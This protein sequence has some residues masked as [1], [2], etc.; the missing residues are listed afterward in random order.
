MQKINI[1]ID[2]KADVGQKGIWQYSSYLSLLPENFHLS[3][4]EGNTP[5]LPYKDLI[6]KREDQNPTGSLKDRGMAYQISWAFAR[7][8]NRL[9]LSSSG[10]AAI[11]AAA[12]SLLAGLDLTV[13]VSPK[14]G[15][16]KLEKLRKLG[17]KVNISSRAVSE[18]QKYSTQNNYLNLRPSRQEFGAEGYQ[19][20]AF[21]LAKAYGVINN[22]FLP[23]SSGVSLTGIAKGFKVL[24][25]LP[26][27][28]LCQPSSLC[29]IASL[30]DQDYQPEKTSLTTA[31]V[32]KFTP[33]KNE[34]IKII[35]ES[36]GTGWVI[37]NQD[38]VHEQKLLEKEGIIT[39]PEGALTVAA[40]T[41]AKNLGNISGKS[42][43]LLT[44]KRYG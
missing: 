41:K 2:I 43:C 32:A 28:H 6:L 30:Y 42:V 37:G 40:F 4:G 33:L 39:S 34:I 1:K 9:A 29:P 20:I 22:L 15:K 23:V 11:S 7:G 25:F 5:G 44:G 19:T 35:K 27:I 26:K 24:G 3:L 8:F 21:E 12:Y 10:N 31:L 18:C 13:Y 36:G 16:S 17:V 38:V 14:I